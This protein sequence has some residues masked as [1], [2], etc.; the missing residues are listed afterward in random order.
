MLDFV[1]MV[2]I[3]ALMVF[4]VNALVVFMDIP[5]GAKLILAAGAGLWIGLA[6]A[7]ASAGWLAIAEPFPVIG[8][9]VALPL[10]A[11]AI[12][13]TWPGARKALL[14]LLLP[15]LI[16]LNIG[17]VFAVLFLLLAVEGR[18]AG[19]FPYFAGLGDIITG[20]VAIPLVWL[21]RE[22]KGQTARI[23]RLELVRGRRSRARHF[24]RRDIGARRA[25]A[26]LSCRSR[27]GSHAAVALLVSSD[28]AGTALFDP[29]RDH[30]GSAAEATWAVGCRGRLGRHPSSNS[31]LASWRILAQRRSAG[32][33]LPRMEG[34]LPGIF[35]VKR[36]LFVQS[37][38]RL[39]QF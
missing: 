4:A 28:G 19:P 36:C 33:G 23:G 18:L 25:L 6:A 15:L 35:A 12:A 8:I 2:V 27:L 10:A 3:P 30:L 31:W 34:G 17:R 14:G 16:G 39:A 9:F 32:C 29:A 5:R 7:A 22:T 37:A 26:A 11:A 24:P 13:T 38:P 20:V 21:A 1:G